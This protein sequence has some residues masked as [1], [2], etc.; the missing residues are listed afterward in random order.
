MKCKRLLISIFAVGLWL[1]AWQTTAGA[2]NT[3]SA[4]KYKAGDTVTISGEITPGQELYI[5]IA[6]EDMFKPSDTDGKFEKKKLPKKGKNAGYGADTAIPPL[7]YMLTTNT[8]AFGN[9]VDKKFGGPSFLFKKGQG[10]YSTTM[11]KLKKNFADVAAADMMGPIKTAEQW[12]F[13][14]FAH[15]NK[16]GINT[17]VK[18]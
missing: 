17:V 2:A 15:E 18:E 11:F 16:Y 13:L 12:N 7:Y 10:L 3:I 6:Q 5:A 9:D 1:I 8:K 4:T 14:K